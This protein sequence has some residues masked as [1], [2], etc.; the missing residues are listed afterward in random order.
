VSGATA[1][2]SPNAQRTV[3]TAR[4]LDRSN[5][6]LELLDVVRQAVVEKP[7]DMLIK[8]GHRI[9]E[10]PKQARLDKVL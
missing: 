6:A 3:R 1:V 8:V 9:G 5:Q 2:S 7:F 10:D 4:L